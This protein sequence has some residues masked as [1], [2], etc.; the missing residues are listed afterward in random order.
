MSILT[1][2]NIDISKKT[3]L[4]KESLVWLKKLDNV[5]YV[6]NIKTIVIRYTVSEKIFNQMKAQW[7]YFTHNTHAHTKIMTI[8][9]YIPVLFYFSRKTIQVPRNIRFNTFLLKL[10]PICIEWLFI[11]SSKV[12][13]LF[14]WHQTS[15]F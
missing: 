15:F 6:C 4:W 8:E 13:L 1:R 7:F 9:L 2:W 3:F 14:I 12:E 11:T 5:S 10:T